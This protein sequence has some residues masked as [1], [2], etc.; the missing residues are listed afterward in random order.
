MD[1]DGDGKVTKE[2]FN[3]DP[4]AFDRLDANKDGVI[5][6]DDD[7]NPNVAPAGPADGARGAGA[8]VGERFR[9]MDKNGDGKLSR[10]E[11]AGPPQFFDRLDA[12]KDGFITPQ[13]VTRAAVPNGG[14]PAGA[15]RGAFA[16]RLRAMDKDGDGKISKDEFSGRA[17]V[18]DRLDANSDG[19][20]T[21]DELPRQRPEPGKAK[22]ARRPGSN[23]V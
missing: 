2:E 16:D 20:V 19:F 12:D 7:P 10:E 22:N 6:R 3:G 17:E 13:E 23:K 9:A 14:N 8:G 15:G 5:S 4:A 21:P 1:K 18:F 11:L